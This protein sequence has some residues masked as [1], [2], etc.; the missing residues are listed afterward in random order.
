LATVL[1]SELKNEILKH[2]EVKHI[3]FTLFNLWDYL[4]EEDFQKM[5]AKEPMKTQVKPVERTEK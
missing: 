5:K 4:K 2:F 3:P 1:S